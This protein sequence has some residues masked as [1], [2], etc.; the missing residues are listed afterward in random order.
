MV[1]PFKKKNTLE[2]TGFALVDGG[3]IYRNKVYSF[4]DVI[5]TRSIKLFLLAPIITTLSR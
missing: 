4:D 5:E 3:F 2:Q 1:A